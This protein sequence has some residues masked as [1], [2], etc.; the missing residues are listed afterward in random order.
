[1]DSGLSRAIHIAATPLRAAGRFLA[2]TGDRTYRAGSMVYAAGQAGW[3]MLLMRTRID[4]RREVGDPLNNSA[5]SAVVGWIARNFPEA[6]VSITL[7]GADGQPVQVQPG[8]DGAG[9][10]LRLLERPNLW[11]SG[12]L[13]WNATITDF[14]RGNAYW[15]K[16]RDDEGLVQQLWWVPERMVEPRWP[17]DD[18]SVFIGWYEYTVNGEVYRVRPRDVIHFRQGL[19]PL[20]PRK[21]LSRFG[22]LLREIFTDEEASAFTASLLRNLGVPG[23]ILA[24]ANTSTGPTRTDPEKVKQTFMEKF[25]GDGRGEPMVLTS[26]TEVKVLSWSPEQMNLREL[27]RIPEERISSVLG[28]PAGVT[29]LG[30]GLDRNTFNNLGEAN[31]SAFT[32]GVIPLHRLIAAELEVQLL[33]DFADLDR[34]YDVAFDWSKASAMQ[35]FADALW[36]RYLTAWKEGAVTRAAFLKANGL[37]ST[38]GDEVY[39]LANNIV[40]MPADGPPPP[41][42]GLILPGGQRQPPGASV[43]HRPLI[44][45]GA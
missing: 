35:A 10:L 16:V 24:P 31:V 28:V 40:L 33:A 26:P 34:G 30:A 3:S 42:S 43:D 29:G 44:G 38:P 23:V 6:P 5:V 36:A 9:R 2:A 13:Q 8:P 15:F 25:G 41:I 32:Q 1:M 20:N 7:P 14:V 37:P 19:D 45:A 11:Y 18:P 12:V 22:A 17:E 21:G 27:R 4:Y 39:R